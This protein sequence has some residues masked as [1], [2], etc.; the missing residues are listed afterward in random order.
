MHLQPLQT[1]MKEPPDVG[2][3]QTA[4]HRAQRLTDLDQRLQALNRVDSDATRDSTR[5]RSESAA[6]GQIPAR[7]VGAAPRVRRRRSPT[8]S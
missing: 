1:T 2:T 7:A 3:V 8:K 4:A 6:D 5:M